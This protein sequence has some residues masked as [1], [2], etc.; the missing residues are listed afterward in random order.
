MTNGGI[1]IIGGSG[2]LKLFAPHG[3]AALTTPFGAPSDR[4]RRVR[5]G[6]H[7][8]WFMARHGDPHRIAPHRVNYRANIHAL[9]TLGCRSI[10]AISAVGAIDPGLE[11]GDLVIID[12][13]I[14]Y[15]WGRAHT[16]SDGGSAPLRHAEF[17]H[18]FDGA[19]R[20]ALIEAAAVAGEQA[21]TSGCYAVTQGP[22]LET[23]AEIAR[24]ARD[25]C[26]V[27]GMTAMPEAGLAR[28]L[29]IDY[30]NLCVVAN[31]AAGLDAEPIS[32]DEIHRVLAR[33][34]QRVKRVV[35]ETVAKLDPPAMDPAPD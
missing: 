2:A 33:S 12:Q 28:E 27:V 29:G 21:V 16:F 9:K 8:A 31:P 34:M 23:A 22:R 13:L 3:S 17:A 26:S 10:L 25:G 18:P 1:G 32:E 30:A 35:I 20:R 6:A 24:L 14:D 5:V 7:E 15:S 19:V 11:A 4:P